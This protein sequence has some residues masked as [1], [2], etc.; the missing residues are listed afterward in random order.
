MPDRTTKQRNEGRFVLVDVCWWIAC[1]DP[2]SCRCSNDVR[3][4]ADGVYKI[5]EEIT[6][7]DCGLNNSWSIL[8]PP[9]S[10]LFRYLYAF[11]LLTAYQRMPNRMGKVRFLKHLHP[12][13]GHTDHT[14]PVHCPNR[15]NSND[16][17]AETPHG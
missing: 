16:Q 12:P 4:N 7:E 5:R 14:S 13:I 6:D 9:F 17:L 15:N 1:N 11:L 2:T 8:L 3:A 10:F